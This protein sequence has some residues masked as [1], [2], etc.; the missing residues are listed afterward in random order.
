VHTGLICS[1]DTGKTVDVF[2]N[3]IGKIH[4]H[5]AFIRF[6]RN[7]TAGRIIIDNVTDGA[8]PH[9]CSCL[10]AA[11]VSPFIPGYIHYFYQVITGVDTT[12]QIHVPNAVS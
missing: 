2:V 8:I 10:L 6:N 7:Y 9:S 11:W 3:V 12:L 5:V 4:Y 1:D